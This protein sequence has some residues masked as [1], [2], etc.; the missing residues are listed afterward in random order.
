MNATERGI[1]EQF[2]LWNKVDMKGASPDP[3]TVTIVVGCG[4]SVHIA[5]SIAASL[6][7]YGVFSRAVAGM[8]GRVARATTF[9]IVSS[10]T[11]WRFR[12]VVNPPKLSQQRLR[13]V[14]AGCM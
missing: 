5:D 13:A 8:N 1:R 11:F 7:A 10:R 4:T 2:P 9:R 12:A 6:N 14:E 3:E